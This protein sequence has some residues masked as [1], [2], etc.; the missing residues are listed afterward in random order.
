MGAP[1]SHAQTV[2]QQPPSLREG[3]LQP[4]PGGWTDGKELAACPR[5]ANSLLRLLYEGLANAHT[6]ENRAAAQER[7]W[8]QKGNSIQEFMKARIRLQIKVNMTSNYSVIAMCSKVVKLS[9]SWSLVWQKT[10]CYLLIIHSIINKIGLNFS[11]Q[12][13]KWLIVQQCISCFF[14]WISFQFHHNVLNQ[15]WLGSNPL[16][17]CWYF[18]NNIYVKCYLS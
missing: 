10:F 17:F 13:P 5:K 8:T 7:E 15:K 2:P 16:L 3:L 4:L 11:P 6:A 12:L 9:K 18:F 14:Y 1:L